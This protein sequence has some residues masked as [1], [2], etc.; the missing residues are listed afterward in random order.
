MD[1]PVN[2]LIYCNQWALYICKLLSMDVP[3]IASAVYAFDSL[4][5]KIAVKLLMLYK[6]HVAILFS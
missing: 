3:A 6:E 5:Q 4:E 1:I 2:Q